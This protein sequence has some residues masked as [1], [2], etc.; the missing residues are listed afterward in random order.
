MIPHCSIYHLLRAL[1]LKL[2]KII[3]MNGKEVKHCSLCF[4]N[5]EPED[6]YRCDFPFFIERVWPIILSTQGLRVIVIYSNVTFS[7]LTT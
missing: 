2:S 4:H 6:Y 7:A 1:A 3:I 5:G